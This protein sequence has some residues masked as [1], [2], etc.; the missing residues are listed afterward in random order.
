MPDVEG[1][2]AT[3]DHLFARYQRSLVA[4]G[5]DGEGTFVVGV[6]FSLWSLQILRPK[7][8]S[9]V[10]HDQRSIAATIAL[11]DCRVSSVT[12]SHKDFDSVLLSY[13]IHYSA[14]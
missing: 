11:S 7:G 6:P 3:V 10:G 13:I 4:A 12:T 8:C 9:G 2:V 14:A 1:S 5:G